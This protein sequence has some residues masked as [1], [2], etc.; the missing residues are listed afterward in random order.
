MTL[1][2]LD[3]AMFPKPISLTVTY[4]YIGI[5]VSGEGAKRSL[6]R[7][8]IQRRETYASHDFASNKLN[9]CDLFVIISYAEDLGSCAR[10]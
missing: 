10:F 3:A 2:V 9:I 5:A 1:A 4:G 7:L 8:C 6:T